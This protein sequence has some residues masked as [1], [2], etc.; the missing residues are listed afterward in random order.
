MSQQQQ[1]KGF[2]LIRLNADIEGLEEQVEHLEEKVGELEAAISTKLDYLEKLIREQSSIIRDVQY[3]TV[4]KVE[5]TKIDIRQN[6]VR[7]S[8]FASDFAMMRDLLIHLSAEL[9]EVKKLASIRRR[10]KGVDQQRQQHEVNGGGEEEELDGWDRTIIHKTREKKAVKV[11]E[12]PGLP[13]AESSLEMAI[14]GERHPV[15]VQVVTLE[16]AKATTEK[17]EE[18]H[19]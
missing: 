4:N 10:R 13:S 3:T 15:T 7:P 8:D 9:E 14:V 18:D 19:G 16:E 11:L 12:G 2:A 1:P 17:K 6:M 5:A